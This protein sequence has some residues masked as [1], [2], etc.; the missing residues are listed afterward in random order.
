MYKTDRHKY[1]STARTWTQRYAMWCE[2]GGRIAGA[3]LVNILCLCAYVLYGWS[4]RLCTS[5]VTQL[6][7]LGT[8][9]EPVL[10]N[11]DSDNVVT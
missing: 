5:A 9:I 7:L 8:N 3:D 10:D 11:L 2:T 1:E 6:L 4:N